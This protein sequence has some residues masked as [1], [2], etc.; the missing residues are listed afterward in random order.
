[1]KQHTNTTLTSTDVAIV[2]AGP[3]G[4]E[5]AASLKRA[6]VDYIQFDARQIGYTIS[7]WPRNTHFFSTSE[8]IAI[9]GIP[10]Q[11]SHQ[12]RITGEEYLTYLRA[13]VEQL[14]LHVNTY[15]SVI[16]IERL[17]EGFLL[18]TKTQTEEKTYR[19]QQVVIAKGDMDESNRLDI[20]GEDLPHVT[21]YFD[22]PHKYFHKRLLIVGGKNSAVEAALRCWRI[23]CNVTL[24]YRRAEFDSQSVKHWI[25]PDVKTQIKKGNIRFF[26]Q[27]LPIEITPEQVVLG[28]TGEDGEPIEGEYIT[29]STDF[30]LLCT[31][32]VANIS[33]FEIAGVNLHGEERIPEYNPETM[34]TNVPGLY[35]A[36]TAASGRQKQYRLFIE[37]CH[38]HVG[39]IVAAITGQWPKQ[40]GTIDARRYD[41]PLVDI[42]AN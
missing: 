22:D 10:I 40:L 33:L 28:P 21:H 34:E 9:A 8:R 18:R 15:E 2:G 31:G 42:Q 11:N 38:Q 23:G 37:N 25:L 17:E 13:V 12:Q 19:C 5:L 6:K 14:D 41:L 3:I 36:G 39:K 1:M 29:H 24:S 35:V 27:T 16:H 26:P 20:P 7:W 32:F 30:V 4:L